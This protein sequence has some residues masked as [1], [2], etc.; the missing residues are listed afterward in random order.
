MQHSTRKL[1]ILMSLAAAV[2]LSSCAAFNRGELV[3]ARNVT[4]GRELMDLKEAMDTGAIS[5]AKYVTLK[6]KMIEMVDDTDFDS[7]HDMNDH[8]HDHD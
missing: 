3:L 8:D 6:A 2:A 1:P 7:W 4:V 5:E